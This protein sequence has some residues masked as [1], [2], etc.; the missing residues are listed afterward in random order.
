MGIR[1]S[2]QICDDDN[3]REINSSE[4]QKL[5]KDYRIDISDEE[6]KKLFRTFDRNNGGSI[7]Y[8]E[9]IKGI[10][11]DMND[12]RKAFVKKAFNKLDKNGN[13]A[14]EPDDIKGV[15]NARNHPD[16]KAGKKTED[17]VLAEFLDTFEYHFNIL[18]IYINFRMITR[19]KIDLL[20][21]MNLLNI[22]IT[23]LCQST[24]ISISN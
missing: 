13:G 15:Y 24:M 18:V 2:F 10:V 11:G 12:F 5:I 19:L 8:D 20:I 14:I 17:E 16:V 23:Y 7:D 9:F 3:S 22:I 4:F 1:R 21:W 6:I